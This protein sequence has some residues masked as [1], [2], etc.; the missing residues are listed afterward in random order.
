[1]EENQTSMPLNEANGEFGGNDVNMT[2]STPLSTENSLPETTSNL[3]SLKPTRPASP[4]SYIVT[5]DF[6]FKNKQIMDH[7]NNL[8]Q[9]LKYFEIQLQFNPDPDK[10][11]NIQAGLLTASQEIDAAIAQLGVPLAKLP[12]TAEETSRIIKAVTERRDQTFN[13]IAQ[14]ATAAAAK[15]TG[16]KPKQPTKRKSS[17]DTQLDNTRARRSTDKDG[18]TAPPRHLIARG[19]IYMPTPPDSKLD[20][21][22][23]S[24]SSLTNMTNSEMADDADPPEQP[25]RRQRIPPFFIKCTKDWGSILPQLKTPTLSSVLSRGNFLKITVASEVEHVRIKNK[26]VYLGLEF[27]CFNLKQDSPVKVMIRGLPACTPKEDINFA[28]SHLS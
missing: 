1:M 7:I 6:I 26:L 2:E 8:R 5:D 24:F 28:L 11:A 4:S 15:D 18:L 14:P 27:K 22:T 19:T 23:N 21:T 17:P 16:T 25:P 3:L 9:Q 10:T 20:S 12:S 13:N